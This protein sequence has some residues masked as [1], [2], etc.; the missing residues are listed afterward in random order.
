MRNFPR[1]PITQYKG[2][3]MTAAMPNK[4]SRNQMVAI[5][6]IVVV[7]IVSGILII[8][9]INSG[10]TKP[11]RSNNGSELKTPFDFR[12]SS[13]NSSCLLN[14]GETVQLAIYVSK[15]NGTAQTVNLTSDAFLSGI[16][17]DF[18]PS[19]G[20]GNFS[21]IVTIAVW[22]STASNSYKINFT[23]TYNTTSH[24]LPYNV[25]VL[26]S[27]VQVSGQ[28]AFSGYS[29][30]AIA[31]FRSKTFVDPRTNETISASSSD[32]INY[33]VTLD[34]KLN[35]GVT[36]VWG[37]HPLG[38][39]A[40]G[41]QP[42]KVGSYSSSIYVNAGVAQDTMVQDFSVPISYS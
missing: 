32:G 36:I 1:F 12:I 25:D 42:S 41:H 11:G 2:K 35:Y 31:S 10:L 26:S 21:S 13:S 5:V 7:A 30:P 29:P 15:I 28:V 39:N 17:C 33:W 3:N 37:F 8:F 22:N 19:S 9:V 40:F 16:S 18:S 24:S 6:L 38:P 23:A 34:N 4:H 27:E 14:Q 20:E